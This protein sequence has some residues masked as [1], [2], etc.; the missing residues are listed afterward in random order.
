MGL[1]SRGFGLEDLR[2]RGFLGTWLTGLPLTTVGFSER[3][4]GRHK[5]DGPAGVNS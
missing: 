5:P 2:L 4:L 1:I 3:S